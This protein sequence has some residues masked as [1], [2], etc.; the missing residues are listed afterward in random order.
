MVVRPSEADAGLDMR[1]V[2]A[3]A[4]G[5]IPAAMKQAKAFTLAWEA[6]AGGWAQVVPAAVP[7]ALAEETES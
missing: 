3:A 1:H 5:S 2:N 4:I 7:V 6:E